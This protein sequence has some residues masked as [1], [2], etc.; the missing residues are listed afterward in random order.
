M[1]RHHWQQT[2]AAT[3]DPDGTTRVLDAMRRRAREE[4][5]PAD[6]HREAAYNRPVQIGF[7]QT[8]SQ[9]STVADMLRLLDAQPGHQIL[10]VGA[11]SGWTTA[12]LGELVTKTGSVLGL[13]LVPQLAERAQAALESQQMPWSSVQTAAPDVLGAPDAAPFDRIL[14]SAEPSYL[15]AELVKQLTPDGVMVINVA[16]QMLRIKRRGVDPDDAEITQH[17]LYRF[18][19]LITPSSDA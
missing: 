6:K 13:E 10:D 5:L 16:G 14:V 3:T 17:G 12:I 2:V 11:G 8:N 18:V 4:F 19:D 1:P 9:P 7:G 15:P